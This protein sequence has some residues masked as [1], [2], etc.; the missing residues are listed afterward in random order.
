M[1]S[2]KSNIVKDVLFQKIANTWYIFSE[3][4]G[5]L[6]YSVMPEGMD[7]KSTKLELYEIIEEHLTKVAASQKRR[8]LEA[9]A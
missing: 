9:V 7:P 6:V 5:D 8:H 3:V 2:A 4:N 1:A